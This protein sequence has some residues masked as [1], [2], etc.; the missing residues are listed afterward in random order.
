M[1]LK[2]KDFVKNNVVLQAQDVVFVPKKFIADLNYVLNM[3]LD[4]LSKGAYLR[5]NTT[6]IGKLMWRIGRFR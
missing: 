4:P 3:V 1:A 2:G 5:N 6:T